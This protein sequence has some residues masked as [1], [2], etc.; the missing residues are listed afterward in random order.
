RWRVGTRYGWVNADNRGGNPDVLG[1]AGLLDDGH[2]PRI[3]SVMADY[4]PSEFSRLR[5]QYNRDETRPE[6]DHQWFLQYTMSLGAH[7]AH[8]F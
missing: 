8:Q 1:E 3:L 4:S 5:V 7:G 2:D 6:T